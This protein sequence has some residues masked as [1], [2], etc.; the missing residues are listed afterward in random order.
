MNSTPRTIQQ[1]VAGNVLRLR[2]ARGVSQV[3]VARAAQRLG[4]PWRRTTVGEVE[5]LRR[6]PTIETLIVLAA[7]FSALDEG[8]PVSP[9]DLLEHD[10]AVE[11]TE[12]TWIPVEALR[13]VLAGAPGFLL[14]GDADST[15]NYRDAL[16]RFARQE[17]VDSDDSPESYAVADQ[18]AARRVGLDDVAAEELMLWLWGE[19]LSSR[20]ARLAAGPDGERPNAQRKGIVTRRLTQELGEGLELYR[21]VAAAEGEERA[22]ELWEATTPV[23]REALARALA[24]RRA[25]TTGRAIR[26]HLGLD[27]AAAEAAAERDA[28]QSI[29]WVSEELLARLEEEADRGDGQ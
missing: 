27:Q 25:H 18:R 29:P 21:A 16:D 1:V 15:L 22:P 2:E 14:H 13:K 11:I 8:S 26:G 5:T 7:A 17:P 12:R 4:A 28:V 24:R 23:Q 19:T 20:S 3:D 6:V 9:V 10:G